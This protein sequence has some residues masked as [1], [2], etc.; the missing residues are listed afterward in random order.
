MHTSSLFHAACG[1]IIFLMTTATF[2]FNLVPQSTA[3]LMCDLVSGILFGLAYII[4]RKEKALNQAARANRPDDSL[5][6]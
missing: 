5:K 2:G 6:G 1:L 4:F 3:E